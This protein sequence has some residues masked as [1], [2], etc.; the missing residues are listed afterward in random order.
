MISQNRVI[1]SAR[2]S[3]SSLLTATVICL[4]VTALLAA[5]TF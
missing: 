2:P 5:M 3:Q 1:H 4:P